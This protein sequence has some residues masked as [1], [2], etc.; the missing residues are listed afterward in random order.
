MT[1][2]P[3]VDRPPSRLTMAL[4]AAIA[5]GLFQTIVVA[6]GGAAAGVLVWAASG[7]RALP[8]VAPVAFV[9]L[10]MLT[11]LTALLLWVRQNEVLAVRTGIPP[12]DLMRWD[13]WSWAGVIV[14]PLVFVPPISA[15]AGAAAFTGVLA[16]G[17]G[18]VVTLA[19]YD[20]ATRDAS[21]AFVFSRVP[22]FLL[23]AIGPF[24]LV[25]GQPVRGEVVQRVLVGFTRWDGLH[26][27][28]I[29][30]NGYHGDDT[31]FFPAFPILARLLGAAVGSDV[32]AGLVIANVSFLIALIFLRKL[33]E[34]ETNDSELAGRAVFYLA[35][36]PT[37][38]FFSA[39]YGE[40]LFLCASVIFF[41]ALRTRRI[42][43]AGI[44]G[45]LATT[46]RSV[47]I[48]LLVPYFVDVVTGHSIT[49]DFVLRSLPLRKRLFSGAA[50]IVCGLLLYMLFL[51]VLTGNPLA[52]ET[53]QSHWNRHVA[54]PWVSVALE[55]GRL[56]SPRPEIVVES[57]IEFAF[58]V[59]AIVLTVC[60]FRRVPLSQFAYVVVS[61]LLPLSTASLLSIPR[62][63]IVMF[64]LFVV[65]AG[66]GRNPIANLAITCISLPLLGAFALLFAGSYWV[67]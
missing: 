35:I 48:L 5:C 28:A 13:C 9:A 12:V 40:S 56:R 38:M 53:V 51:T 63:V 31:A 61:L 57:S 46:T 7:L 58:A 24:V 22:V 55:I 20:A 32:M 47:G 49:L 2:E 43:L 27:L 41:Y 60:S 30:R 44:M 8:I 62:F 11:S 23:M 45:G 65:L 50:F 18:K 39:F 3:G 6:L 37:A 59:L 17:L 4:E 64:P 21:I 29:A 19:R 10:A 26:Y 42:L 66:W 67:S 25:P 33:L 36:F 16:F 54:P 15:T 1:P 34:I 14:A 52:F